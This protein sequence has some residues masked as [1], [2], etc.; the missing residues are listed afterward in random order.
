[1]LLKTILYVARALTISRASSSEAANLK[2]DGGRGK[3]E[4]TKPTTEVTD[5]RIIRHFFFVRKYPGNQWLILKLNRNAVFSFFSI[6]CCLYLFPVILLIYLFLGNIQ[7]V[8]GGALISRQWV[9]TAAHCFYYWN[10]IFGEHKFVEN[11]LQ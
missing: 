3:L 8:C 5:K 10:D 4:S 1:M 9:L 11:T 7:L 2:E 6:P